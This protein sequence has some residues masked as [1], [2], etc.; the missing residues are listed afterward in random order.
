M[1]KLK[2]KKKKQRN[3]TAPEI[4]AQDIKTAM[5]EG[6]ISNSPSLAP[7]AEI[8]EAET[9]KDGGKTGKARFGKKQAKEKESTK[10]NR[11]TS[12]A[13]EIVFRNERADSPIVS[14]EE[15]MFSQRSDPEL[16]QAAAAGS[17]VG[18]APPAPPTADSSKSSDAIISET[19]DLSQVSGKHSGTSLSQSE[20][21]AEQFST[22]S[23]SEPAISS[24]LL[25]GSQGNEGWDNR[26]M[27]RDDDVHYEGSFLQGST[28]LYDNY[29]SKQH[30]LNLER[31]KVFLES[32][33]EIE[34][35]DLSVLHDWDGW[36]VA[37]RE[38][39]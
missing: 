1:K 12:A 36:M 16:S 7:L 6:G 18:I 13:P 20:T 26:D 3:L 21:F 35:L 23:S 29:G 5:S 11:S 27:G 10:D 9:K 38:I 4:S 39:M 34:P 24:I 19:L 28:K 22:Q 31:V 15:D 32:S 37:S 33:G 8:K 14:A 30:Q 2:G 25:G 17:E